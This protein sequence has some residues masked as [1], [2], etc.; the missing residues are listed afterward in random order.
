MIM[1]DEYE[2]MMKKLG[3]FEVLSQHLTGGSEKDHEKP[4][5]GYLASRLKKQTQYLLKTEQE[6]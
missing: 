5:S 6:Y 1:S 4:Q 3:L 2:R